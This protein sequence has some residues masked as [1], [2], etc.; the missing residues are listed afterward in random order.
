M[1]FLTL[2]IIEDNVET[3]TGKAFVGLDRLVV[4]IADRVIDSA[5]NPECFTIPTTAG[6]TEPAALDVAFK[7]QTLSLTPNV[8]LNCDIAAY[9]GATLLWTET[10]NYIIPGFLSVGV[11]SYS[12]LD[13]ADSYHLTKFNSED[14]FSYIPGMRERALVGACNLLETLRWAGEK[15]N[16]AQ[17]L[18]WPRV[19]RH[20]R[21]FGQS[22]NFDYDLGI[23]GIAETPINVKSGQAELA[24]QLIKGFSANSPVT[25]LKLGPISIDSKSSG[26]LPLEVLNLVGQYMDQQ[27]RLVRT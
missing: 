8:Y 16:Y 22:I 1:E 17:L 6:P 19:V 21:T 18:A 27:V 20:L 10:R 26:I 7:F 15:N 9:S 24:Y 12:T 14:W 5:V 23:L 3:F 2:S 4:T 13:E 25:R 11:N